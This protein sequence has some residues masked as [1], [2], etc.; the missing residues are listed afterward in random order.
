MVGLCPPPLPPRR[1]YKM[2][3]LEETCHKIPNG[4]YIVEEQ[5]IV[6]ELMD[7]DKK[8]HHRNQQAGVL[9]RAQNVAKT[10]G[11]VSYVLGDALGDALVGALA[12]HW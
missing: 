6:G 3:K 8:T 1:L 4:W 5:A 10:I 11:D 2:D 9:S 7:L 12:M